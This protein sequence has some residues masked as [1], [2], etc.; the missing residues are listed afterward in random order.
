MENGGVVVVDSG[1]VTIK[2]EPET[3]VEVQVGIGRSG[4]CVVGL[5]GKVT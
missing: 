4:K 5:R 2:K 3:V 1:S